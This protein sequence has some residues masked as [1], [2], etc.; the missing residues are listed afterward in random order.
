MNSL[1]TRCFLP[2]CSNLKLYQASFSSCEYKYHFTRVQS[3]VVQRH[4]THTVR[5]KHSKVS[6]NIDPNELQSTYYKKMEEASS[7]LDGDEKVF[8]IQTLY[9]ELF[10][11]LFQ[12]KI[13][14]FDKSIISDAAK[15]F[16]FLKPSDLVGVILEPKIYDFSI[17]IFAE[18]GFPEQIY[19][20]IEQVKTQYSAEAQKDIVVASSSESKENDT[21]ALV[22]EALDKFEV[23]EQTEVTYGVNPEPERA[24]KGLNK[25][26]SSTLLMEKRPLVSLPDFEDPDT[27]SRII[28]AFSALT[29]TQD[30]VDMYF[31]MRH[32]EL[33]VTPGVFRSIIDSF[34]S[35]GMLNDAL[36]FVQEMH[37]EKVPVTAEVLNSL[38]EVFLSSKDPRFIDA[39][40]GVMEYSKI[41]VDENLF[42]T[43]LKCVCHITGDVKF[44]QEYIE[45]NPHI[46]KQT[47]HYNLLIKTCRS[48]KMLSQAVALFNEMIEKNINPNMDTFNAV[49]SVS[50]RHSS[51]KTEELFRSFLTH[52]GFQ[53]DKV[54]L[55]SRVESL[56]RSSSIESAE[57]LLSQANIVPDVT[58]YSHIFSGRYRRDWDNFLEDL[59]QSRDVRET[60]F[61]RF[62]RKKEML[63]RK[64]KYQNRKAAVKKVTQF[65]DD[66]S[67]I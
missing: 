29:K 42:F 58:S 51:E 11:K 3:R 10:N 46:K 28:D 48:S 4:I 14:D 9:H 1:A 52:E 23:E 16:H 41:T 25:L 67:K 8:K 62:R 66:P 47:K 38:L 60:M 30:V 2:R 26:Q 20:L 36:S 27:Y 39:Y 37:K 64:Q 13:R 59:Q 31:L 65:F 34:V 32:K 19:E 24:T 35:R 61:D 43:Y 33:K 6:H 7:S 44:A 18:Q 53:P 12:N 49:L 50:C 55:S 15:R 56:V 22:D 5:K 45:S 17:K 21:E 54:T 57:G 40:K 63:E